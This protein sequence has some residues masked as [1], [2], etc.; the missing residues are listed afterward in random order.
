MKNSWRKVLMISVLSLCVLTVADSLAAQQYSYAYGTNPWTVPVPVAGGFVDAANGNLHIEIPIASIPERGHVPFTAKLVYDSHIWQAAYVN[1]SLTWQPTN[2]IGNP[3]AWSGWRLVTSV[4]TGG[5]ANVKAVSGTCTIIVG[6]QEAHPPYTDYNFTWTAPDGHQVP[7]GAITFFDNNDG[8][9]PN[10][11]SGNGLAT[12][13]SG[14]HIY[15]T[16]YTSAVVYAPDGTQ[17]FPFVEDTNGNYFSAPNSNGDVTD[18]V[19]RMPITTSTNGST[20]TYAIQNSQGVNSNFLLTTESIPV[21]TLFNESTVTEYSGNITV[22][23]SLQLPDGTS[24]QFGYDQ[25]STGTHF[26]ALTSMTLPTGGTA[27][28][29]YENFDDACGNQSLYVNSFSAAGGNWTFIPS[30]LTTCYNGGSQEM[31]VEPPSGADQLFTFTYYNGNM[32]NTEANFY[33]GSVA[34]ANLLKSV[35]ISYTNSGTYTQPTSLVTTVPGPG[36]NLSSKVTTTYDTNGYGNVMNRNEWKFTSGSFPS[37][38]DKVT[39]YTYLTNPNNNMVNKTASI[40]VNVGTNPPTVLIGMVYDT[41]GSTGLTAV[42]G[43]I[44]HDDTNF[45][46]S[47]TAR[48]NLTSI[49]GTTGPVAFTYDTTGQVLT[50]KD[51]ANNVTSY[52]YTDSYFN[53]SSSGPTSTT[54]AGTTNAFVTQ[55]TLPT[56]WTIKSG[57][58]LGTGQVAKQTDQNSVTSTFDYVDPLSRFTSS[59]VLINATNSSW[60]MMTYPSSS[61]VQADAYTGIGD[62][63]PVLPCTSCRHDQINLDTYGRINT[64][65]LVSDPDGADTVTASYDTSGRL[66]S[67][68]NPKRS[69]SSP[70]DG[71]DSYTYDGLGRVTKVTHSDNSST[72]TYYGANVTTAAGGITSQ[73]CSSATYGLGYPVLFV[74]EAGKSRETWADGFGRMIEADEPDSTGK[75]TLNTCYTYDVANNLLQ[76]VQGAQT[77]TYTYYTIVT[78]APVRSVTSPETGNQLVN[79]YYTTSGGTVCSGNPLAV[80]R[81]TDARGITTTYTYDSLNRLTGMSY[82]GTTHAVTYAYDGGTNQKGYRTGMSD[83]SGS[84]VWTYNNVGWP[85]TEQRTIAG[86]QKTMSYTYNGDGSLSTLTYPSGRTVTYATSNAQRPTSAQDLTNTVQYAVMASY[87]PTGQ[88]TTA[89]YGPVAQYPTWGGSLT[90]SYNSRLEPTA[91]SQVSGA[92]TGLSLTFNYPTTGNNGMLSGIT[93]GVT[94]GLS[95]SYTYDSLNRILSASTTAASGSGCWGQSFGSS[96]TPDDRYGNLSQASVTK[97]SAGALGIAVSTSTNQVSTTGFSYD[98]AGN[99]TSEPAPNGYT[100]TY[101]AENHLTQAAGTSTGTWTYVYDGNGLRVEKSNAA[102]GTLYWRDLLGNSIAETDLTGSTTDTAYEEYVFFAGRRIAQVPADKWGVLYYYADQ[103]GS[104]VALTQGPGQD[105]YQ[106]TFTPYGQEM[107]TETACSTNYKFAGYERDAET[108][109]DYAFARFYNSRLDRFMSADPMGG[110]PSAPQSLNRY[111]YVLNNPPNYVDPLGLICISLST[112]KPVNLGPSECTGGD[113]LW[114]DTVV[115]VNGGSGID[116]PPISSPVLLWTTNGSGGGGAFAPNRTGGDSTPSCAQP[117]FLNRLEIPVLAKIAAM[118]DMTV[119]I[120]LSGSAG[121]GYVMGVAGAGS[122]YLVVSPNGDAAF[123]FSLGS[124][125]GMGPVSGPGV[126][127]GPS[128]LQ[129]NATSPQQLG[130][131]SVSVGASFAAGLGGGADMSVGQGGTITTT[132]TVGFGAGG[133]GSA[134]VLSNS[135]VIPVCKKK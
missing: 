14:Y 118:F 110:D 77:R 106:A 46:V 82:T 52:S 121:A 25:G 69:G 130:G 97:C 48:G 60:K 32:W 12:D 19:G 120:G 88:L 93:N 73:L 58:Y 103:V 20:V 41:Y 45:G 114:I 96:G 49:S 71:S 6:K 107:A 44:K 129:S 76:V 99:M 102:G 56:S 11:P 127:G 50:S 85:I 61:E 87:A 34:P 21:K 79:F 134:G 117:N 131:P 113:L 39:A 67:V 115:V 104:T 35:A 57:Y 36:G 2:V 3:V 47:Y 95:E 63:S 53:D 17:V 89:L 64:E 132:A 40:E 98:A 23:K 90:A 119:G 75:L 124:T 29:G 80:C 62:P 31:E 116:T 108:G 33:S 51:Q 105:C 5:G 66:A 81:R 42:T 24:Y 74:D 122:G 7:F 135:T 30:V 123:V 78:P 91:V 27:T 65:V 68:T 92:G 101:D 8:C 109:L 26:G 72:S 10:A 1:Q 18:T 133:K 112:M 38:P 59:K 55:I 126:L 86:V 43:V 94:S 13:A 15:V 37:S 125:P 70:T 9:G 83:G 4:G 28:Y 54:A 22:V 128:I 84:T 16:N 111:A 100:Y